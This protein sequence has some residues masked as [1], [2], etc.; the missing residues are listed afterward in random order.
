MIRAFQ[1]SD[2][3]G[4]ALR[5]ETIWHRFNQDLRGVISGQISVRD[6]IKTLRRDLLAKPVSRPHEI[7]TRV[8]FD[9]VVSDRYTVIDIRAQDR[10]GLLY[11][12]ASTL[13]G[14]DVDVTLAKIA[15]ETDQAMDVFYV[16]EK[17]GRKVT[18]PERMD[19]IRKGL[20]HAIAEGIA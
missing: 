7:Q 1:V 3:R 12:I 16:T 13:S 15:T 18:E 19:T 2:G 10:L 20:V 11:V 14:L 9:N 8:E 6:L 5:D 4:A 17:N